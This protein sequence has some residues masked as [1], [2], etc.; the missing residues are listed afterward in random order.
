MVMAENRFN[1]TFANILS[2]LKVKGATI[3]GGTGKDG[4][5]PVLNENGELD[6]SV[7]PVSSIEN[8]LT[9][10]PLSI[11]FVDINDDRGELNRDGSIALPYT[12]LGAAAGRFTNFILTQGDYGD[13]GTVNISNSLNSTVNIFGLGNVVFNTLTLDQY[14]N[15]TIFRLYNISVT[16]TIT[17]NNIVDCTVILDGTSSINNIVS[18]TGNITLYVGAHSTVTTV[19]SNTTVLYLSSS[20]R[21]Q[22]DSQNVAGETVE[23]AID[24]LGSRKIKIPKFSANGRG[25]FADSSDY[26][27]VSVPSDGD[28][29]SI[30]EL[31]T[32][33][34]TA[35]NGLFHKNGDSPVYNRITA[36][37]IT[38]TNVNAATVTTQTLNFGTTGSIK[39]A[40]TVDSN[41]FLVVA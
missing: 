16:D 13:A 37:N 19:D 33:L 24:L 5:V 36:T 3:T 31:G 12:S 6:L 27:D 21:I 25:I 39:A 1:P 35:M 11:A 26:V 9:I 32:T 10:K 23:D 15:G 14:V 34:V 7:I 18:N 28:T 17:F 38:S 8:S 20:G 2:S 29:Y 22:N 4:Y 40:V 41:N 30:V